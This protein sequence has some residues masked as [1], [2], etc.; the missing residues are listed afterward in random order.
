MLLYTVHSKTPYLLMDSDQQKRSVWECTLV[1]LFAGWWG[2]PS[3]YFFT[4]YYLVK[5]LI[6]GE[7]MT[8]GQLIYYMENPWEYE[9]KE[10]RHDFTGGKILLVFLGLIISVGLLIKGYVSF[11]H[12]IAVQ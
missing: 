11:R 5:D 1:T 4:P 2:F 6:G 8:V 7:R 12:M 9:N 10:A 3:G